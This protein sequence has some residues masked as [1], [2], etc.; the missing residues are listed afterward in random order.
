MCTR[1]CGY[2]RTTTTPRRK[3]TAR[4]PPSRQSWPTVG[5]LLTAYFDLSETRRSSCDVPA[6]N[7]MTEQ[8]AARQPPEDTA[9]RRPTWWQRA[10]RWVAWLTFGGL[11]IW[12]SGSVYF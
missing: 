12:K 7:F 5:D 6:A 3:S 8:W 10:M 9:E 11:A 2:R 1:W 4:W